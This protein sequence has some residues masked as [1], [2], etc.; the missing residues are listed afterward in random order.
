VVSG[1][2]VAAVDTSLAASNV[3]G[4]ILVAN[5]D[6]SGII[7]GIGSRIPLRYLG[8][9][10]SIQALSTQSGF[11][12]HT[13]GAFGDV[14]TTAG[15]YVRQLFTISKPIGRLVTADLTDLAITIESGIPYPL[16][17]S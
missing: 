17:G 16:P 8:S 2:L 14:T 4:L 13:A 10:A 1:K 9:L 12:A 3:V 11:L 5:S 7:A 15:R 6:K